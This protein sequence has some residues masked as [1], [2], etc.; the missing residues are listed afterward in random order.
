MSSIDPMEKE[1]IVS[2]LLENYTHDDEPP[3]TVKEGLAVGQ[4]TLA[5]LFIRRY[6]NDMSDA[7]GWGLRNVKRV[8]KF[9]CKYKMDLIQHDMVNKEASNNVGFEL[10][11]DYKFEG[12]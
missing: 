12:F 9:C 3:M 11:K 4:Y 8:Y 2:Y 6:L 5:D 1:E 10:W 7:P